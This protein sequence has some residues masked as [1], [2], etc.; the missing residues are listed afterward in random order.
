MVETMPPHTLSE[1][2]ARL[3]GLLKSPYVYLK[4]AVPLISVSNGLFLFLVLV[5]TY[6]SAGSV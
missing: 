3:L 2:L 4:P 5:I 1:I 6:S